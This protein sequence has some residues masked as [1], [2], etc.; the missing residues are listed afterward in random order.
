M[1]SYIIN[2]RVN[3]IT[4]WLFLTGKRLFYHRL[5]FAVRSLV[6]IARTLV[7]KFN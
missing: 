6:A 7:T 2:K 4:L 1:L 5:A 3:I